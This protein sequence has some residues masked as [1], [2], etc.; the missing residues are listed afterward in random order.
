VSKIQSAAKNSGQALIETCFC[1]AI[2]CLLLMGVLQ[3]AQLFLGRETVDNAATRGGRAKAVGFNRFML[4][5][6]VRV[7]TIPNAGKMVSPGFTRTGD[8]SIWSRWRVGQLWEHARQAT[9]PSPQADV[10][11]SRV[12]LYLGAES[13]GRL[14]AILDYEDWDTVEYS[15]TRRPSS[16]VRVNVTQEFP[17]RYGPFHRAFY[18][19]DRVDLEAESDLGNHYDLYLIDRGL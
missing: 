9:P 18:A 4:Y 7:G 17:L 2:L 3:V 15:V 6:V 5:K 12:P 10:E 8:P 16:L 11:R 13:Y 14:P 19:S 1:M